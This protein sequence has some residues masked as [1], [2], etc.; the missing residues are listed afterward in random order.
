MPWVAGWQG[1]ESGG[2]GEDAK[3]VTEGRVA[4]QRLDEWGRRERGSAQS[5]RLTSPL[6]AGLLQVLDP[7]CE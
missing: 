3:V 1:Q 4:S 2:P 5:C 7:G 6:F